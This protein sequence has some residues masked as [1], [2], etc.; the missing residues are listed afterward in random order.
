[1]F[2]VIDWIDGSWKKT[3]VELIKNY[4][5]SIWKKVL[6][7]DYPRYWQKSAFM[8][9]KYLNWEYWKEI[10]PKLASI[11]YAIDRFDSMVWLNFNDY[12]FVLSNRYVSSNMIHQAWK[13]D[14]KDET[15][16][17][18]DWLCDLE[19]GIFWIPRPDK[20]VFLNMPPEFGQKLVLKKEKRDYIKWWE[21]MDLHE[22]D[23]NHLKKAYKKAIEVASMY[24]EWEIVDCVEDNK[25]LDK[26][27]ITQR[28]LDKIL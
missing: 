1:M 17:F 12:D 5:E 7:L 25:I 24:D 16:E 27:I 19:F 13:I 9:E 10:S 3:Q 8:V 2:I 6:V 26:H 22:K 15:K 4:L 21:K 14:S 20:V 18:L 11:F 23:L 28:I